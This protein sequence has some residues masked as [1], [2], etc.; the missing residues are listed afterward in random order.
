[1]YVID[2]CPV[3]RPTQG[4]GRLPPSPK[5]NPGAR[6][7]GFAK[8][9]FRGRTWPMLPTEQLCPTPLKTPGT[10]TTAHASVNHDDA[11]SAR[12]DPTG[13][14]GSEMNAAGAIGRGIRLAPEPVRLC[15]T[16]GRGHAGDAVTGCDGWGGET[17]GSNQGPG[18]NLTL[19][20]V[21][22][23]IPTNSGHGLQL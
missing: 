18:S 12:V 14:A 10:V 9:R 13:L 2:I 22:H 21:C 19:C 7:N 6:T 20:I 1:M 17:S 16:S 11:R 3:R 5:P 15:V 4:A 8:R 23:S